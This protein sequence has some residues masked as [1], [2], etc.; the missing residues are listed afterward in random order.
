MKI[1][2]K[3]ENYILIGLFVTMWILDRIV[4]ELIIV[5]PYTIELNPFY[6]LFY[7]FP[8]ISGIALLYLN[9]K[10]RYKQVRIITSI[11]IICYFIAIFN[12]ILLL[13]YVVRR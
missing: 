4:T 12:N 10:K 13:N 5:N 9:K 8:V 2:E 3:I 1:E 11:L 6:N 7:F